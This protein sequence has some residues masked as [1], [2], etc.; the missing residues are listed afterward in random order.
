MEEIRSKERTSMKKM[1]NSKI[2][3]MEVEEV[4]REEK[5]PGTGV[6]RGIE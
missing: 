1:E 3:K 6:S 4:I 5:L 2:E